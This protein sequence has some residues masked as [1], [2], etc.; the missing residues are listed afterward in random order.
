MLHGPGRESA[1]SAGYGY[2]CVARG[3]RNKFDRRCVG[4]PM[5]R[6]A[7]GQ[8]P[9]GR[10]SGSEAVRAISLA[11]GLAC[12][13][14]SGCGGKFVESYRILENPAKPVLVPPGVQKLHG[15]KRTFSVR[16]SMREP[17]CAFPKQGI[18]ARVRRSTVKVE[19]R[20]EALEAS[21]PG[22]LSRWADTLSDRG[23]LPR[24]SRGEFVRRVLEAFPLG[25]RDTYR[26]AYGH[27]STSDFIDI[28]AGQRLKVVGPVLRDDA[29]PL[30]LTVE[31]ADPT[32]DGGLG[33]RVRSSANL[34]GYEESWYSITVAGNGDLRLRHDETRF[35]H[36]GE[37]TVLERPEATAVS[38]IPQGRFTR[39]IYLA[40]VAERGDHDVLFVS[41]ST[42]EELE[43]RSAA[44]LE[45]PGQCLGANSNGWCQGASPRL[46]INLFVTVVLNGTAQEV[47]PG[48]PLGQFL[49]RGF[50]PR[51][52]ITPPGLEVHRPH[53]NR[54]VKVEFDP[55][56]GTI[57]TL[58][59]LGGERILLPE[60]PPE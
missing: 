46:A 23:C 42:R 18:T 47:A 59:L 14:S 27:P 44:V 54:L 33:L 15:N 4:F 6:P 28:V 38:F 45:E 12:L 58:P 10:G 36:D 3:N 24:D 51:M 19:I 40:R 41:G 31:S 50:G 52:M 13:W 39:M 30:E 9:V 26:I 34:A 20:Q 22:R 49:R 7:A 16:K 43:T 29:E 53:G 37:I 5:G 8:R 25:V 57:M 1:G 48:I 21:P 17:D 2:R 32:D 60:K 56:T 55:S 35:F 11:I